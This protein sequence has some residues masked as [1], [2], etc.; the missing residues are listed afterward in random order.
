MLY[1]CKFLHHLHIDKFLYLYSVLYLVNHLYILETVTVPECCLEEFHFNKF[2]IW[3]RRF[4]VCLY[5]INE[6]PASFRQP[7]PDHSF[8]H[9]SQP[10]S[11]GSSVSSSPLSL[12]IAS[13]LFHSKLTFSLN[14]SHHHP[15]HRTAFTDTGLLNG[16]LFSFF[17]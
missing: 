12:S 10:N 6:L 11:L 16:F 2:L 14:P 17:H 7:N 5:Y 8:T 13:T 3:D 4:Q 15:F 1:F 9:F